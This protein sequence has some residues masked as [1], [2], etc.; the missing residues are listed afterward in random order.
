ME[1]GTRK[2]RRQRKGEIPTKVPHK[3]RL[4]P[5]GTLGTEEAI[6]Q[7]CPDQALGNPEGLLM[8]GCPLGNT[9]S[10]ALCLPRCASGF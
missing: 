4:K 2:R 1:K 3:A 8:K 5:A 10:Q 6:P 9:H 7:D